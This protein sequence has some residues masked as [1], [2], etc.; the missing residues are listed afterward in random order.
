MK[1][2]TFIN[3]IYKLYFE[4]LTFWKMVSLEL[5]ILYPKT[6]LF[7]FAYEYFYFNQNAKVE[8]IFGGNIIEYPSNSF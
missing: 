1:I 8:I 7:V 4:M 5:I 2:H 3:N 6:F